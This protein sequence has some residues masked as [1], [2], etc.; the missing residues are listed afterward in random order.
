MEIKWSGIGEQNQRL[1]AQYNTCPWDLWFQTTM[2]SQQK[3][4]SHHRSAPLAQEHLSRVEENYCVW[5]TKALGSILQHHLPLFSSLG[6]LHLASAWL[7]LL[8]KDKELILQHKTLLAPDFSPD[9]SLLLISYRKWKGKGRGIGDQRAQMKCREPCLLRK[10]TFGEVTGRTAQLHLVRLP[11]SEQDSMQRNLALTK[12]LLKPW[13][14]G[15][16]K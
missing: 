11:S 13:E 12:L 1:G 16:D 7:L 5:C 9:F 14:K 10:S 3:K 2:P 6:V 4:H 15:C 8:L